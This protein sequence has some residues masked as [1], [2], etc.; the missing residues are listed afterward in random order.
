VGGQA[1][2]VTFQRRAEFVQLA[3]KYRVREFTSQ[4]D[5][6]ARGF[7]TFFDASVARLLSP[8]ELELLIC[9]APII[10]VDEL[11]KNCLIEVSEHA[12]MLWRVL[13]G[14]TNEERMRF[15]KFGSGR[16]SLP[17]PGT[18]WTQKLRI[19]FMNDR[20]LDRSKA[21][22][23]A[24]TCSAQIVIPRYSSEQVMADKIRTALRMGADI[25]QDHAPNLTDLSHFT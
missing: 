5:A 6:L 8:W 23:T 15:I 21:L 1:I 16:V 11:K 22:P 18:T 19:D 3:Q 7:H 24:A 2:K 4:L 14:F 20:R 17:S 9:G 12:Q 13:A 25:E 10:D